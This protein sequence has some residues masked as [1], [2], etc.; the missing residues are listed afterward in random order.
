MIHFS[1]VQ[2][3]QLKKIYRLNLINSITGIKPANVIASINEDNQT[4]LAIISSVVHLG[5]NP[6]LLGFIMRPKATIRRHT[7][8]NIIN[9]ESYTIN[10]VLL[11]WIAKAHF[12][13]AKFP[14]DVSEFEQ[15]KL[16]EVYKDDF[17]VPYVGES[18]VQIGM[19]LKEVIEIKTNNTL[20]IVGSIEHLYLQKDLVSKEGYLNLENAKT[21][22][23]SG[24][25]NYYALERVD[26]FPYARVAELPNFD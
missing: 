15:C 7:Y 4:N 14:A 3:D 18:N 23:I 22:G 25:N 12:T 11:P 1:K 26:S 17:A 5:S 24:L 16:T 9:R 10:H 21:A 6:G 8:E 2:L 13:S 20:M 19:A